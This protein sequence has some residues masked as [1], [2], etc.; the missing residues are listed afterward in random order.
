[1]IAA[2]GLTPSRGQAKAFIIREA[3]RM[4]VEAQNALL[5]T[6]EEP[7]G[8]TY[9][10]LIAG[11]I[12]RLLPTTQSRCQVVPFDSLPADFVVERL[13]ALRPDSVAVELEWCARGAEGSLGAALRR[14]D[15]GL[16]AVNE[17]IME[18]V[19]AGYRD[20]PWAMVRAWNEEASRIGKRATEADEYLSDTE[21]TRIGLRTVFGLAAAWFADA[22]RVQADP[23][24][25]LVNEHDRTNL[26]KLAGAR[27]ADVLI[28]AVGR[29]ARSERQLDLNVHTALCVEA[30][31][32]ELV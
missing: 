24:T 17:R 20:G 15:E 32:G 13:R 25:R 30:L 6:L 4:N 18:S 14:A 22:I 16:F 3:D 5:K 7:P 31:V 27:K 26:L 12:E 10:V 1:M 19:R 29:I 8:P 11:S 21:A 23:Q 28:D 9:L 2:V